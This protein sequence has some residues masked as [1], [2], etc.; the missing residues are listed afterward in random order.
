MQVSHIL[1]INDFY[2]YVYIYVY[3]YIQLYTYACVC[4]FINVF[5]IYWLYLVAR[6]Q[7]SWCILGF[8]GSQDWPP[9]RFNS[10]M[11]ALLRQRLKKWQSW[12]LEG[13]G[14]GHEGIHRYSQYS[15]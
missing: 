14:K 2:K 12:A 3:M 1:A 13:R 11:S 15:P 8:A 10:T 9:L 5:C 6:P 7:A 4:V